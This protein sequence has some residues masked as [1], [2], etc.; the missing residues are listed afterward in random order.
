MMVLHFLLPDLLAHVPDVVPALARSHL[1]LWDFSVS[2]MR[3]LVTHTMPGSKQSCLL[4]SRNSPVV[5]C[6][7][8]TGAISVLRL[9][10][11]DRSHDPLEK[12]LQR[13]DDAL[14]ANVIKA[15]GAQA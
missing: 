2:T 11:V 7:G 4:F 13:L 3:P 1:Q 8:D 9:F 15:S 6:G 5:V 10:N 12:Q 14:K